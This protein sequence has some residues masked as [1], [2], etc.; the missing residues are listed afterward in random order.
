MQIMRILNTDF[1]SSS[2]FSQHAG[3]SNKKLAVMRGRKAEHLNG[4]SDYL[5]RKHEYGKYVNFS[6]HNK[7]DAIISGPAAPASKLCG[8]GW[9]LASTNT[10][11]THV[12]FLCPDV[13]W[14]CGDIWPYF[15]IVMQF[16]L[17][18]LRNPQRNNHGRRLAKFTCSLNED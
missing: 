3:K 17:L 8:P 10:V 7:M 12:K 9:D 1:P 11:D 18:L 6:V 4:M 14:F 5:T 16:S 15:R 13:C 2:C